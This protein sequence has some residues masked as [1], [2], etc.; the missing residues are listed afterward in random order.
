MKG[1]SMKGNPGQCSQSGIQV[2]KRLPGMRGTNAAD[3]SN[4]MKTK[5]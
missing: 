5:N 4:K 1:Q 3:K 2:K